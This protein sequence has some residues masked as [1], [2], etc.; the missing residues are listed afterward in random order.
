MLE[1]LRKSPV[2]HLGGGKSVYLEQVR[3]P[4]KTL[5]L[6][7]EALAKNGGDEKKSVAIV[8]GP[9]SGAVSEKLVSEAARETY[10]KSYSHL[11][12]VGF[13]IEPKAREFVEQCEVLS[14]IPA[15]YVQATPD[16]LMGDLL[17]N[18][19]SSQIFSVC[20]LPDVE[21]HDITDGKCQIELLGLDTFDPSTMESDHRA[22]MMF[23]PGSWIPITTIHASTFVRPFSR[24]RRH[25]KA[26]RKL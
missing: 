13:A 2:L 3:H 12:V 11:Y 4:A 7:A 5:N 6:S 10:Q 17:K 15:T 22:E 9:E 26:S 19:R 1:I 14:S 24:A 18:M 8:F 25:G 20:G 16:I 21:V 23:L